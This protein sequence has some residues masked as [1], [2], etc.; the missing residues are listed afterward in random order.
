MRREAA[1]LVQ[2]AQQHVD[3]PVF[4]RHEGLDLLLAL[5]DKTRGNRLHAPGGQAAADLLPQQRAE[6]VADDAV[7][8][9]AGLLGVHQIIIDAARLL[10]AARYDVFRDLVERHALRLVVRQLKQLLQ[11][12]RDRLS[13]AVRVRREI[14]LVRLF[15]GTAQCGKD[16]PLSSYRNILR[17]IIMLDID[18]HLALRE[19]PHMPV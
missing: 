7:K 15:A 11:M 5:H 2:A 13:L 6:L 14:Y 10:N 3:C 4:L 17:F 8:D 9:P 12:P 1:R 19:I 18:S 16:I